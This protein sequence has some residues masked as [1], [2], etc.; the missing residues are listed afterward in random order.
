MGFCPFLSNATHKESC[1]S[2]CELHLSGG[3]ALVVNAQVLENFKNQSVALQN[4]QLSETDDLCTI[5]RNK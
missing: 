1:H 2:S 4:K 3:C 5:M